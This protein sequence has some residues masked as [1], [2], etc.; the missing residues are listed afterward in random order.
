MSTDAEIKKKIDQFIIGMMKDKAAPGITLGIMKDGEKIQIIEG[1]FAIINN[2]LKEFN[3][4]IEGWQ[5][6][7]EFVEC[8]ECSGF[9]RDETGD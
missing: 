4:K 8:S 9:C 7:D 3:Q 2:L 5:K 6:G 1:R